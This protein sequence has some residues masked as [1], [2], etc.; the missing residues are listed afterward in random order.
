M[1]ADSTTN[2]FIYKIKTFL[3]SAHPEMHVIYLL[4]SWVSS[5]DVSLNEGLVMATASVPVGRIGFQAAEFNR[6]I[7]GG[8]SVFLALRIALATTITGLLTDKK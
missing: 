4:C 6:L 8:L 3:D 5:K 2:T 7:M 1:T